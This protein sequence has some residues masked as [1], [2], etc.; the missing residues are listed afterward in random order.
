MAFC[1]IFVISDSVVSRLLDEDLA[2]ELIEET[3]IK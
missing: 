2:K 1:E 3:Y